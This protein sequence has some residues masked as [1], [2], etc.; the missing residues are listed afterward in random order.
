VGILLKRIRVRCFRFWEKSAREQRIGALQRGGAKQG[1]AYQ[2]KKRDKGGEPV[3]S[4]ISVRTPQLANSKP[5][6][7]I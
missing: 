2:Q 1:S 4:H 3:R 7:F 5:H 6:K